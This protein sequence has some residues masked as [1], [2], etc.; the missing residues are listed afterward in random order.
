VVAGRLTLNLHLNDNPI[1]HAAP[2][3]LSGIYD[4]STTPPQSSTII[5]P[6]FAFVGHPLSSFCY[7]LPKGIR[8]FFDSENLGRTR[9]NR[10]IGRTN[11]ETKWSSHFIFCTDETSIHLPPTIRS[12]QCSHSHK[13]Y[14]IRNKRDK[15]Q[16]QIQ[17]IMQATFGEASYGWGN[18][19]ARNAVGPKKGIKLVIVGGVAGG[20]S[21]SLLFVIVSRLLLIGPALITHLLYLY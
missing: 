3:L 6:H 12:I 8:T 18:S 4:K 21:V 19:A 13:K 7:R 15:N 14:P 5:V 11:N 20:A 16:T 10:K 17:K 1:S 9:T 2:L